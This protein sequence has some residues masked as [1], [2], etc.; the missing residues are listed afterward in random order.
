M[1]TRI[2]RPSASVTAFSFVFMP[3]LV[4]SINRPLW[5]LAALFRPQASRRAVCLEIGCIGQ[6]RLRNCGLRGQTVHY[7]GE[8]P[9]AAPPL[10]SIVEGIRRTAFLGCIAP[11][12]TIAIEKYYASQNSLVIDPQHAM[13]I[14]KK[15]RSRAICTSLCQQKLLI[16]TPISSGA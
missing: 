1:K 9:L 16:I 15:G 10:P 11:P 8:R 2:R 13:A 6:H 5:S 3:P 4:R 7:P 14:R 12:Q